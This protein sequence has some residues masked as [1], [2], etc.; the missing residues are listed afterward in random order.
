MRASHTYAAAPRTDAAAA[1]EDLAEILESLPARPIRSCRSDRFDSWRAL[2]PPADAAADG[3]DDDAFQQPPLPSERDR[4]EHASPS[5]QAIDA[6][7][8]DGAAPKLMDAQQDGASS[9]GGRSSLWRVATI[10]AV[11]VV[12]I[13]SMFVVLGLLGAAYSQ[14]HQPQ[15]LPPILPP[16]SPPS[17]PPRPPPPS[18]SPPQ[19]E[20]QPPSVPPPPPSPP[21]P[22]PSPPPSAPP[23]PDVAAQ[24]NR[25]WALGTPS[26]DYAHA[27]VLLSVLDNNGHLQQL[28]S[29]NDFPPADAP[30]WIG[31]IGGY[32]VYDDAIQAELRANPRGDRLSASLVS[33]RHPDTYTCWRC[34][35]S[36][37]KWMPAI[38]L[39]ASSEVR[40]RVLCIMPRD[41]GSVGYTCNP[42]GW[43]TSSAGTTEAGNGGG[44]GEGGGACRPGC[45]PE[46]FCYRDPHGVQSWNCAFAPDDLKKMLHQQDKILGPKLGHHDYNVDSVGYNEVVLDT[47]RFL[48]EPVLR[49][50]AADLVEAVAV[51]TE[52]T[53]AAVDYGRAVRR[54]FERRFGVALPLLWY[55]N[56]AEQAPFQ[57]L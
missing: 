35:Q 5:R 33:A 11:A 32:D 49:E 41:M 14:A 20:P 34:G 27:G 54:A 8:D 48:W 15:L 46:P 31:G 25:R 53:A 47:M 37:H 28:T 18:P 52:A 30:W 9:R 38:V 29:L 17:T 51:P 43:R 45:P 4:K 19:R 7:M 1:D 13:P 2:A 56:T 6:L 12:A 26:D 24:L 21:P 3:E 50:N 40:K 10:L 39:A 22:S 44:G 16:P 42:L 55:N 36:G 23:P 57:V